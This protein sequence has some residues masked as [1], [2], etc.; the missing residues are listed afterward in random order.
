MNKFHKRNAYFTVNHRL[1]A[2]DT[3][4]IKTH[5]II[6]KLKWIPFVMVCRASSLV[7]GCN[8][9][10]C[11]SQH[12]QTSHWHAFTVKYA[13]WVFVKFINLKILATLSISPGIRGY[14]SFL[15]DHT[16]RYTYVPLKKK[17]GF[18]YCNEP[19]QI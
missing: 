12:P 4:T 5:H 14:L 13:F 19:Q 8:T 6:L 16:S 9:W 10:Y 3:T 7:E 15:T 1:V 2:L 11:T 17:N 18:L